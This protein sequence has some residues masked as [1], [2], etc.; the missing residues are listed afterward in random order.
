MM[1]LLIV[2]FCGVVASSD[3]DFQIALMSPRRSWCSGLDFRHRNLECSG[4]V[5]AGV[6][7][8]CAQIDVAGRHVEIKVE[9]N[10]GA[11]GEVHLVWADGEVDGTDQP[12]EAFSALAVGDERDLNRR[13]ADAVWALGEI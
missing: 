9:W 7:D 13:A 5:G 8:S 6:V 10:A 1:R 11:L 4:T 2:R 12:V 3:N